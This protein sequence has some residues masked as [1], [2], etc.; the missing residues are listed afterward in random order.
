MVQLFV[1]PLQRLHLKFRVAERTLHFLECAVKG[2]GTATAGA[3]IFLNICQ[4]TR[5][6][7]NLIFQTPRYQPDMERC[8][9]FQLRPVGFVPVYFLRIVKLSKTVFIYSSTTLLSASEER[10]VMTIRNASPAPSFS[11]GHTSQ[12]LAGIARASYPMCDYFLVR[13]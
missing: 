6:L 12:H 7:L 11:G 1:I 3:F 10:P 2:N 4:K 5:S 9:H 8:T 13:L